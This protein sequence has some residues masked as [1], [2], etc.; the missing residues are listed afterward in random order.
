MALYRSFGFAEVTP[1]ET[2]PYARVDV[3]MELRL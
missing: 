1:A 2:S 3:C